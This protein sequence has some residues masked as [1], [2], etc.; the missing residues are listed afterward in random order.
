M[1]RRNAGGA[2]LFFFFFLLE[3]DV[4]PR[5]PPGASA[6]LGTSFTALGP[7]IFFNEY[8]DLPRSLRMRLL[9]L[10]EV[11]DWEVLLGNIDTV[12]RCKR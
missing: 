7:M 1:S 5:G 10:F 12:G 2:T 11:V 3:M 9:P 6:I 4:G 8:R